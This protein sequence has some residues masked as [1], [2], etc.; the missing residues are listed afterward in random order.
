[1]IEGNNW[2]MSL[3]DYRNKIQ[4]LET[5]VLEFKNLLNELEKYD[6]IALVGKFTDLQLITKTRYIELLHCES[7]LAM[8]EDE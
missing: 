6:C 4:E 8:Q 1:M 7:I 3:D 2:R 5:K